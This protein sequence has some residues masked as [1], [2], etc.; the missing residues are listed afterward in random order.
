MNKIENLFDRIRI[1]FENK[2]EIS[3]SSTEVI[4]QR[5]SIRKAFAPSVWTS[6][7]NRE[8]IIAVGDEPAGNSAGIRTQ[9]LSVVEPLVILKLEEFSQFLRHGFRTVVKG[10][11]TIIRP[12]VVFRGVPR[13]ERSEFEF[14]AIRAGARSVVFK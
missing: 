5:C 4:F 1:F 11:Q 3:V 2:I 14:A 9:L 13:S 10:L 8:T 6:V 7:D 12:T